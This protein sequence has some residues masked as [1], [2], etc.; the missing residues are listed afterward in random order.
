M[1]HIKTG[2]HMKKNQINLCIM[3]LTVLLISCTGKQGATGPAGPQKAGV[4]YEACFQQGVL[5][6]TYSGQ[7]EAEIDWSDF[8]VYYTTNIYPIGI[9]TTISASP[10]RS[11]IKFDMSSLPNSK[12]MVDKAQLIVN[13]N[14]SS[15]ADG[16]KNVF[17]Y[18]VT[19]QWI[20]N[21]AGWYYSGLF[22]LPS[23]TESTYW[24]KSGGDFDSTTITANGAGVDLP[25]NSKITIDLDPA[26]VL[27]WMENPSK[28]YGMIFVAADEYN[29]NYSEIYS[30]GAV[31]P[32]ARP[33]LKI[34][35][36]TTE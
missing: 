8:Y 1:S 34:W 27:Y 12:I 13:T 4:Y 10:R 19:S 5:P 11:I 29:P 17:I 32:T 9:G 2:G 33:L 23:E 6:I 16:V 18:K 3:L 26:T 20:V 25:P 15:V 14:N 30:S 22:L 24:T 31:T 35:Y 7:V 28:N 36:Y 21:R